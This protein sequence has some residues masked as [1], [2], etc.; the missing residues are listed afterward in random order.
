MTTL[1]L[2]SGTDYNQDYGFCLIANIQ[3]GQ[4]HTIS[5]F[6]RR[7]WGICATLFPDSPCIHFSTSPS[8]VLADC[9][10]MYLPEIWSEKTH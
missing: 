7:Q 3:Y 1:R 2:S 4:L 5:R 6:R 8:I 10:T 9:A